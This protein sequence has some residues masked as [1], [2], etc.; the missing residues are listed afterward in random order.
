MTITILIGSPRKGGNTDL[1]VR[2]FAEEAT[3]RHKIDIVYIADYDINPCKGCNFCFKNEDNKCCQ[4]DDMTIIYDKL[5]KTDML[6]IA[7]PVY[8]Y[9]ISA[10]LKTVIDRLHNPI[11]NNFNITKMALFAVGAASLPT[12]FDAI[13]T[14]YHLCLNFFKIEDAGTILVPNVKDKG[15]ILNNQAISLAKELGMKI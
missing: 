13:T 9:G 1:L 6:I 5:S 15:D 12:L 4:K 11:R 10:Q 7:S 2:A 3:K 14:Q 8:F